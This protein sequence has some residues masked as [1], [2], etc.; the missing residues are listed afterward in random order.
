MRLWECGLMGC[1][2]RGGSEPNSFFERCVRQ[3]MTSL[4]TIKKVRLESQDVAL[5]LLQLCAYVLSLLSSQKPSCVRLATRQGTT[6]P[7]RP[8][9]LL[10][11]D[12]PAALFVG[13]RCTSPA[14]S[15][16]HLY[17]R[18]RTNDSRVWLASDP[19]DWRTEGFSGHNVTQARAWMAL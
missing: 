16:R 15:E 17:P 14:E 18:R 10:R 4:E 9:S 5:P 11:W 6:R 3:E 13:G 7:T 19:F 8:A 2:G 12:V 1:V